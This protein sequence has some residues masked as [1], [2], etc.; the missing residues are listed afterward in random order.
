MH[1]SWS[2]RI[3]VRSDLDPATVRVLE[4]VARDTPPAAVDL[5]T[6]HPVVAHYLADWRRLLVGEQPPYVG[7]P[8]RLSRNGG[9][10]LLAT[11]EF[12]QHDDEFANGGYAL[13]VWTL[14]LIA[15]P[16][17]D[18]ILVGHHALDRD[19]LHWHGIIADAA[20][21]DEGRGD[22]VSWDSIDQLWA[23]LRDDPSWSTWGRG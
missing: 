10:T 21:I 8:V 11:I 14:R 13:W 4:A 19:D 6:L 18:R 3:P 2:F 23:E 5:E 9:G 12:S 20:G 16:Q 17:R 7:S 22:I 15:R 1:H